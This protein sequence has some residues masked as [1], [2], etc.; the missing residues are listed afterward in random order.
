M[1]VEFLMPK[2]GE[3]MEEGTLIEWK[4][5]EGDAVA[6]DESILEVETDKGVME[7]ESTAT[8]VIEKILVQQGETVAVNTPLALIA[9]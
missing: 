5:K 6:K 3:V 7:I 9:E 2:L 4:K 1:A 8:G